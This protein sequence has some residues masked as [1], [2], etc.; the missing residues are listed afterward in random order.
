M[1]MRALKTLL[2][3][4]VV[5]AVASVAAQ[6]ADGKGGIEGKVTKVDAAKGSLTITAKDGEQT[7]TVTA[8]TQ[9]VGPRGGLV[10]RRLH[11][12]RF[13]EGLPITVVAKGNTATELLL[14]IDRKAAAKSSDAKNS[15]KQSSGFRG[16]DAAKDDAAD[17]DNDFPGKI[18]SVDADK[19]LLVVTLLNGKD[20]S[21]MVGG[22]AKLTIGRRI[23]QKGL[24]DPALKPGTSLTVV[25]DEGGKKVKEVKIG[26]LAGNLRGR[27]MGVG[28]GT[29]Q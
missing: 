17:D 6:A 9:I 18:K 20:R 24:S 22:D 2:C 27:R 3:A 5:A 12:P 21:F 14:G 16:D 1:S 11:D 26:S 19:N 7:F 23:S 29:L 28:R 10:R 13:H 15:T 8:G 4:I 25:T